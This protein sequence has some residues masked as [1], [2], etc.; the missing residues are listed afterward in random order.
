[1]AI[2]SRAAE[3][4]ATGRD[5][6]SLSA[7]EPD[8]PT[9][10]HVQDAAMAAMQRGQT[11]Y[12]PVQGLPSLR[13]AIVAKLERENGLRFAPEEI[14]VSSGAKQSC[15]N[16]CVALLEAGDEAIVPAPYWVS[17]P[18][19]VRLTGAEPVIIEATAD[20][21]FRMTP[22]QLSAALGPQ[23]RLLI[24]NSPCNPTGATYTRTELAALGDVLRAH[25]QVMVL[26]DDIYEHIYWGAEPFTT[27]AQTCPD[28]ADRT[29][30]VN[31][32][33][34][35]YAMT[36]WRIGYAAGPIW[37]IDAMATLQSQSTTHACSISQAAA[38]T[39]LNGP[40]DCVRTMNA[41]FRARYAFIREA[42]A[43][44]PGI[45]LAPATGAFYA[46]PNVTQAMTLTGHA[47]DVDFATALLEQAGVAVVPGSAF[48]A[49][50]HI[51]LSFACNEQV[52]REAVK[53][54]RQ[55]IGA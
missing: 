33:S 55:F 5:V 7:G 15:Y 16:V 48:G 2:T 54:L 37:L 8:F 34:K 46:F 10:A 27:F 25:P 3:L 31:G 43:A 32:V 39:A 44:L 35:A 1:V 49:A 41:A 24:M 38:E 17:Y 45:T 20:A 6:I 22:A 28:L 4:R 50:G 19:M 51:R 36:G 18:D 42:L 40:Q 13:Q 11:R 52:L 53:R 9:P 14:I 23:T 21:G 12:T 26:T 30:T 47:S 29:I